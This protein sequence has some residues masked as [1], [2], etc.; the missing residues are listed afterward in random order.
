MEAFLLPLKRQKSVS[1]IQEESWS[2]RAYLENTEK[3][4]LAE[5]QCRRISM[6]LESTQ[7]GEGWRKELPATLQPHLSGALHGES[8]T[9]RQG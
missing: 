1:N 3:P 6:V 5:E 4:N 7:Q 8:Y 9:E 2:C